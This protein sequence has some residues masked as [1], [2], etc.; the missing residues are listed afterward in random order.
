MPSCELYLDHAATS[1]MRRSVAEK[2]C[3]YLLEYPFNSETVYEW[4]LISKRVLAEARTEILKKLNWNADLLF[5]SGGTESNNLAIHALKGKNKGVIWVSQTAHPSLIKPIKKLEDEGW[6][7]LDLPIA[8]TG[9]VDLEA[10]KDFPEPNLVAIEWVNSEV[11]FIQPI[12]TLSSWLKETYPSS[13]IVIDAVQGVGKIEMPAWKNVDAFSFSAHKFGGPIGTGGL[14]FRPP[15]QLNPLQLGGGQESGWRSGTIA[16]A[17]ILC[18]KD[19]LLE[20]YKQANVATETYQ[21][22][23]LFVRKEGVEYSSYLGLIDTRPVDGEV[24]LHQLEAKGIAMGLGSACQASRKKPSL[25]LQLLGFQGSEARQT[26]RMSW[27]PFTDM[28]EI[29]AT[30]QTFKQ[31][32]QE[33][34]RYFK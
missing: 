10:I 5:T 34:S 7:I 2:L 3:H 8:S 13:K 26:L 20:S 18:M 17:N 23:G 29:E 16:L 14:A 24:L 4:G 11:G 9:C 28:K 22:E 21:V 31:L 15:K 19:A 1:P 6:Q 25:T 27:S 33:S 12:S 32:H 30:I